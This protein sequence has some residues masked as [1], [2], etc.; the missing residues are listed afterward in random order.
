[1]ESFWSDVAWYSMRIGQVLTYNGV[2]YTS[3][4]F[5]EV[6]RKFG[7][8]YKRPYP[9][10]PQTNGKAVRFIQTELRK[11]HT[12]NVLPLIEKIAYLPE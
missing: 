8:R 6:W 10:R 4:K 3:R 5:Y 11:R 2:C 7:I 12:R 1:M 9:Y